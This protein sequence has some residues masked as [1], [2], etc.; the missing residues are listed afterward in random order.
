[1]TNLDC[2]GRYRTNYVS[3]YD[4]QLSTTTESSSVISEE[5]GKGKARIQNL[6]A[7]WF[8]RIVYF[9]IGL[10]WLEPIRLLCYFGLRDVI[11]LEAFT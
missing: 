9:G 11:L 1:M 10:A 6:Y 7:G 8:E 4:Q 5:N 3:K 2:T